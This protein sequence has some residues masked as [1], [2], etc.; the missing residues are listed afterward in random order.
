L[1]KQ[2]KSNHNIH[3][4]KK[5]FIISL[6][7]VSFLSIILLTTNIVSSTFINILSVN[8]QQQGRDPSPKSPS[9]LLAEQQQQKQQQQYTTR[10]RKNP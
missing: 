9:Q 10:S 6:I 5:Y 3:I 1:D 4:K 7:L 8:A 2:N